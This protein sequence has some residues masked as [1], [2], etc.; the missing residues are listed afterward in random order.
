[1]LE[2]HVRPACVGI[3]ALGL[4]RLASTEGS[5]GKLKIVVQSVKKSTYFEPTTCTRFSAGF[6]LARLTDEVA[7]E[8][9]AVDVALSV[10]GATAVDVAAVEEAALAAI[11]LVADVERVELAVSARLIVDSASVEVAVVVAVRAAT[12][13]VFKVPTMKRLVR[14]TLAAEN[15]ITLLFI[16][17]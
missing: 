8:A 2:T 11:I 9:L 1:L 16:P 13:P 5:P 15:A 14:R 4:F 10:A 7:D 6:S 12:T 3:D 17:I